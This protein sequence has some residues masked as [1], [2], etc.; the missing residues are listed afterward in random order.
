VT[1]AIGNETTLEEAEQLGV[2]RPAS[3]RGTGGPSVRQTLAKP[4]VGLVVLAAGAV[5]SAILTGVKGGFPAGWV[6]G[7]ISAFS[8]LGTWI[9]AHQSSAPFF[10]DVLAPIGTGLNA[11]VSGVSTFLGWLTWPGLILLGAFSGLAAGRWKTAIFLVV[12]IAAFGL[13]GLW[14]DSMSTLSLMT[15]AVGIS[16][17]IGVPLGIVA[18]FSRHFEQLLRPVL[19]L[20][21]MLPA[22]A[23]L[24]PIVIL[25]SIGNPGGVVATVIYATPPIIR[26]T[27]LGIRTVPDD[28]IEAG[29][30]FGSNRWQLLRKVQLPMAL[31]MILLGVNQVIMMALSV[32]VIAS[33]I[34]TGGL[35]DPVLQ[36]LNIVN[37][38]DAFTAG[39][40]I[41]LMAMVLD[42]V[43]SAFG[44]RADPAHRTSKG[45]PVR[46]RRELIAAGFAL[47]VV[48]ALVAKLGFS[49]TNFPTAWSFSVAGPLNTGLGW[50]QHHLYHY[51]SVPIVGGTSNLSAF[52]TLEILNPLTRIAGDMPW[53][54]AVFGTAALGYIIGGWRRALLVG[55]CV[56]GIGLLGVW[57][58]SAA[59]LAQVLVALVMCIIVGLPLGVAAYWWDPVE[60][61]LRPVLD[62]LQTMPAFVY[63]IPVV[64]FFSVGNMAG[65]TASFVYALAPAVRLTNLGLRRVPRD[66]VEAGTSFGSTRLQLLRKVEL[67]AARPAIV[68]A[69]NQTILLVLA[70]VIVA[71]L[72][73][74]GGLGY[75]V[76]VGLERDEFGLGLA[77]GLAI[78]VLGVVLDR[79][80]QGREQ[81]RPARAA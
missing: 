44:E 47:V 78:V 26:L 12:A 39:T 20:M 49:A 5:V 35:G 17:V 24:V 51:A 77:A 10:T 6:P 15:V 23:Y 4:W 64:L 3:P 41:V 67:P 37:V 63:L 25:F 36:A 30:S 61:A 62:V 34:G 75:D 43:V 21:Q 80:T 2:D 54:L 33:L 57:N 68:L 46:R 32:V 42:R 11:M 60:K 40:V 7:S 70:E 71:G 72:V 76:V 16:V 45:M 18:A 52:V 59:T 22:Y 66:M 1:V 13:L 27:L 50:L 53:W 9:T 73:G 65:V 28:V 74:A 19:D 8:S 69:I 29:K 31:R 56:T 55:I 81:R 48:T 79:L 58:D 14:A 38:G